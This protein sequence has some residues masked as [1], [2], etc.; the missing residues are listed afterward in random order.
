MADSPVEGGHSADGQQHVEQRLGRVRQVVVLLQQVGQSS[1]VLPS[2]HVH[3][4]HI[5]HR[6][7][8]QE[9]M[10]VQTEHPETQAEQETTLLFLIYLFL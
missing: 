4:H 1:E 2:E 6:V 5:P 9:A 7:T 3:H 10:T 8:G